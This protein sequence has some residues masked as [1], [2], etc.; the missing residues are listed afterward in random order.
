MKGEITKKIED[1]ANTRKCGD[2][3]REMQLGKLDSLTQ[4]VYNQQN[5]KELHALVGEGRMSN[6]ISPMHQD[7]PDDSS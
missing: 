6:L 1:P 2:I 5:Y 4:I 7:F 3:C